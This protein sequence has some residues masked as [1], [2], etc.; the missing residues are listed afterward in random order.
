MSLL[1]SN[2][3]VLYILEGPNFLDYLEVASDVMCHVAVRE[4]LSVH[5]YILVLQEYWALFYI[6]AIRLILY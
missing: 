5:L 1:F 2:F 6:V 3:Q 4:I